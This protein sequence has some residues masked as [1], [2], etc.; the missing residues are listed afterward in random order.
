MV[1]SYVG[2]AFDNKYLKERSKGRQDE[3]ED[4]SSYCMRLGNEKVLEIERGS[5]RSGSMENSLWK[6]H[7][8]VVRQLLSDSDH[9]NVDI[10]KFSCVMLNCFFRLGSRVPD[11]KCTTVMKG[12]LGEM[13]QIY[14]LFRVTFLLFLS[15]FNQN[16]II[17]TN[18]MD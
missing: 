7:R 16:Y 1:T 11:M 13:L 8:P 17:S 5:T 10:P 3:E 2:T 4:V 18:L 6:K 15:G 14:L 9:L 12:N